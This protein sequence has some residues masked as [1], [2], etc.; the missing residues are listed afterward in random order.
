VIHP[1]TT[2]ITLISRKKSDARRG[3]EAG[4]KAARAAMPE[5]K[6]KLEEMGYTVVSKQNKTD[7]DQQTTAS[8]DNKG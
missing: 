4:E 8:N 1:D 2:G 6:R 7:P 5:I 3:I